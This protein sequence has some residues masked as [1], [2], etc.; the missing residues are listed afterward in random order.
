MSNILEDIY[1]YPY[2]L[3]D[4][5][6]YNLLEEIHGNWIK[7]AWESKD[8]ITHLSF[9]CS[10]KTTAITIVG[11]IWWILFHPEDTILVVTPT[12]WTSDRIFREIKRNYEHENIKIIYYGNSVYDI[13]I[14]DKWSKVSMS[15][16]TKL[17][18]TTE[19]NID[20][21]SMPNLMNSWD[22]NNESRKYD[23]IICDG[24]VDHRDSFSEHERSKK[25]PW[26]N[27]LKSLLKPDGN[28]IHV[29]T[30][31]HKDDFYSLTPNHR[32]YPISVFPDRHSKFKEIKQMIGEPAFQMQYNLEPY[33]NGDNNG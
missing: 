22:I 25:I 17:Q 18:D 13:K 1:K 23:K 9:K 8:D 19:G 4:A 20:Q 31:H 2:L 6:G 3:G 32:I 29:G 14:K 28:I 5:L 16:N 12:A 26:L 33:V 30:P 15:L 11:S 24:L 10:Y 27:R 21:S 7:E